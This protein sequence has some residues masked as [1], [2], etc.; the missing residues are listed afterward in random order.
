MKRNVLTMAFIKTAPVGT[1]QD[2]SGLMLRVAKSGGRQWIQR[3]VI[4]G[5]RRDL[6]LGSLDRVTL[7]QAR[8]LASANRDIARSGGDPTETAPSTP[9][10][11][12]A[13]EAVIAIKRGGWRAGGKSER[14]WKSSIETYAVELMAMPVDT[15]RTEHVLNVLAPIWHS[16]HE[17]ARRLRQR[18]GE[19]LEWA[20]AHDHRIDNPAQ[21]VARLLPS[22]GHHRKHHRALPYS[23]VSD[24]LSR[25]EAS[26][27]YPT[28]KLAF[29]FLVLTAAR[30]GEVRG[31]TWNEVD[32]DTATWTIPGER[33]KA[34]R[35]HKVPLSDEAMDVLREAA[36]YRDL[37]RL[38]FPAPRGGAL[39][40]MTLSKLIREIGIDAVPHGF[41]ASFRDWANEQ[42]ST[43]HAVMESALAH[44]VRDKSE[45]AYSRT[46]H[47]DKRR[48]L[49][50]SWAR[51][52][53]R[54]SA[55]V[56]SIA[57]A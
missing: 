56:V 55:T 48:E 26:A 29:A 1:H 25:V 39:S 9:T 10:F 41:R 15:I 51:Y 32:M 16:R 19:C 2:G 33:M 11:R 14:Q 12:E 36:A 18:I 49:M 54:E 46:D 21:R 27:A 34:G 13:F 37:S 44:V 45:A 31:A 28:T 57:A 8:R 3:V 4:R 23:D 38:C 30:S 6:G 53:T 7:A 22:N 43:P 40:D 42:T 5:E 47:L 50:D 52:L 20:I 24:A 17:T 35:P